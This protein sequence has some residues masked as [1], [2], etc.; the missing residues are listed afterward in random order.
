MVKIT[1]TFWLKTTCL[2]LQSSKI[3]FGKETK[4]NIA[5]RKFVFH[6]SSKTFK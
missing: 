2:M 3:S 5:C 6:L 1:Y 4:E